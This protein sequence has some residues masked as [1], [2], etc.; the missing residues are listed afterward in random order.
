MKQFSFIFSAILSVLFSLS[1]SAQTSRIAGKIVDENGQPMIAAN[2]VIKS[3]SKGTMTDIDGNYALVVPPGKYNIFVSYLGY[4]AVDITDIEV[5]N[6]QTATVNI[7]M[8]PKNDQTLGTVVI[9]SQANRAS[10]TALVLEQKN[11]AVLF[12]GMSGD[13]IRKTPDRTTADVLKR[14]SGATIQDN[15]FVVVRGLPDRYN[16]AFLNGAPLPSSEPDRKA[17]AFD[18]FPSALLNDLKVIKT[19][20]PSLPGEFAGG[21]IVVRT[22]DIPEKNYYNI[23]IGTNMNAITSFKPF[24]RAS[25]GKLDMLG[26]DDGTRKL[27]QG[28]PSNTQ[29]S[30]AQTAFERD[31]LVDYAK[32]LRNNYPI[33]QFNAMPGLNLQFSMGHIANLSRKESGNNAGNKASLGSVFAITYNST[34][35]YREVQRAEF[36]FQNDKMQDFFDRQ[37]SK[38]T[39]WGALW[40]LAFS[41]SKK[42]GA[43]NRISLKNLY[44]VNTNDQL[45]MRS[46]KDYANLGP[47]AEILA[48]NMYYT[49]NNLFS[50]QLNG[51]HVLP[52]S[53]IRFDWSGGYSR[54]QR[55]IPDYRTI[56]YQRSDSTQPFAVPISSSVQPNIAGRFF[57]EQLDNIYSGTFDFTAPFKLGATRHEFKAGAFLQ[58]RNRDFGARQ[59]GYVS[60]KSSGADLATIRRMSIDS[61]FDPRNMGPD[62]LMIKE[63]TKKSDTYSSS[64]DL[65]AAYLQMESSFFS[66]KLKFVYGVRME[67][68]RQRLNTFALAD[69]S[70][71]NLDS[72]VLDFLP[73]LNIIYGFHSKMNLR[74]SGSQTVTR[75]ESRELA[76]FAFYDFGLFSLVSG[77]PSLKRTKI[78]NVDL[79]YEYFPAAGQLIS[80]TGFYKYFENPI[81]RIL[82]PG[83]SQR[84]F[85]YL[86][87][88][89]AFSYGAE[90]EFRF[91]ISSFIK[92]NKSRFLEDLSFMGNIAYIY[93]QVNLTDVAGVNEKRP[94]Q[95]QSPFIFN[96]GLQYNDSKYDFGISFMA[97][98]IGR[99]I[100]TVGNVVDPTIWENPRVILDL[101][102][103]KTF[104]KR[105]LEIRFNAKDLLAQ[106]A[107][108]YEDT[109]GNGRYDK[110][111]DNTNFSFRYGQ[112][113]SLSLGYN[114]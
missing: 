112:Q 31:K 110:T 92:N 67:N 100:F 59:L 17:F 37:Y 12:D 86:N 85:N 6:G 43:N 89:S 65:I 21:L 101:Q 22:K 45:V 69:E 14:V 2:V 50:S 38:N 66:N 39:S 111:G 107:N 80:V 4:Q 83:A 81:E 56:Q 53:K 28:F 105:K 51:E 1:A 16:A 33:R 78:T 49:Q 61:I 106:F 5:K 68:F 64:Q 25:G 7:D 63:A 95:G 32:M 94:M 91:S 57:S 55:I 79:R 40:N 99:R 26:F 62:G 87:V 88:P 47:N 35:Q 72:T 108:F 27:A 76:P 36:D 103:T 54:L 104:L 96:G 18:I 77:N 15:Q 20:M 71:I 10:N 44:N 52:K 60:Y 30:E 84:T 74:L 13:Q 114:F 11:S 8:K 48:Y 29:V 73:S 113:F 102:L 82:F 98:Y 58:K 70:P 93:S 42:N 3:L 41:L 90:F 23:S 9:T 34:P 109:N 75:P 19:A 46:G 24:A 97:N